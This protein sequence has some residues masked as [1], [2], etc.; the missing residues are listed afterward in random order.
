MSLRKS[1]LRPQNANSVTMDAETPVLSHLSAPDL[2][3]RNGRFSIRPDNV[4]RGHIASCI[5][6]KRS[7]DGQNSTQVPPRT[8]LQPLS[9]VLVNNRLVL[10]I[11]TYILIMRLVLQL[12]IRRWPDH[13]P[14][15]RRAHS[16]RVYRCRLAS[17]THLPLCSLCSLSLFGILRCL[18]HHL[19]VLL[20]RLPCVRHPSSPLRPSLELKMID[21]DW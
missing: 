11:F 14:V 5:Y 6:N 7:L 1:F 4:I 3:K 10:I 13:V 2:A 9:S 8:F 20:L 18:K 17:P 21:F 16:P 12:R 19:S 15:S